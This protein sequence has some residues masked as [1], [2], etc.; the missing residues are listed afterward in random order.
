MGI[1]Y[2]TVRV[3]TTGLFQPVSMAQGVVGIIG[4]AMPS[5]AAA[6]NPE[7]FTRPLVGVRGEPYEQVVRVI[8]VNDAAEPLDA[9]GQPLGGTDQS[10]VQSLGRDATGNPVAVPGLKIDVHGQF[11]GK[12]GTTAVEADRTSNRPKRFDGTV[13]E[14]VY[15]WFPPAWQPGSTELGVPV[16]R[17]GR[18][19]PDLRVDSDGAYSS[20]DGATAFPVNPA[21]GLPERPA[22][23]GNPAQPITTLHYGPGELAK[24]INLALVNGAVRVWA[25][26]LDPAGGN[27]NLGDAFADFSNRQ[28]NLVCLSHSSEAGSIS[29]LK[30]HVEQASPNDAGG[31]GTRPR[32]G[33]AMLPPEGWTSNGGAPKPSQRLADFGIDWSSSRMVLVA[34]KSRDD[35]AAAV[36]GCIARYDPWIS[37]TMKEVIGISQAASFTDS[38]LAVWLD[39][40]AQGIVQPR[41]VPIGDPEFLPGAGLVLGES[42]TADGTGQRQYIDIVRS[43]DDLAFRLKAQLTNPNVIGTMRINRPGLTGLRTIVAALLDGRVAA[44]E[45]DGYTIDLPLLT[46]LQKDPAQ[47]SAEETQQINDVQNSRRLEFSV[48]VD[49]SG[50]IHFL[51]VTL[52]LV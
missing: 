16:D 35:A 34:H 3:D 14:L 41:V 9:A 12:D 27:P 18:P 36:A 33:V 29:D 1:Q 24:S 51:I 11:V 47:R 52:R 23:G 19:I 22:A 31:G 40:E 46:I 25:F 43:I 6:A 45:I 32:M 48:S 13:H 28:I 8:A 39:P 21:T 50:S 5:S 4:P 38:E 15:R 49:Y 37:L 42:F 26:R 44:G 10:P 30:D 20:L 17:R 7:L 2:V